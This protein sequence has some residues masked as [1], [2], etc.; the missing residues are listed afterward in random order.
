MVCYS[1][2]AD[3]AG[4]YLQVLEFDKQHHFVGVWPDKSDS[5]IPTGFN[6]HGISISE[7]EN[8]LVTS[9]FICPI[10]T[11]LGHQ[12]D[13]GNSD[14]FRGSVRYWDLVVSSIKT[15][16]KIVGTKLIKYH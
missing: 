6:P 11:I 15:Q 4:S 5:N 7:P 8:L 1:H 12:H 9:D 13:G 2:V 10:H 16:T 3:R 14:L